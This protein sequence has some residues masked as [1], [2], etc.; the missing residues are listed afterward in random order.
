MEVMLTIGEMLTSPLFDR[1]PRLRIVLA[2]ADIGWL[3]WL[4]A[5]VDRGH[6]RYALQNDIHT[7]LKPSEYFHRN[8]SAVV[9]RGSRRRV[10]SRIHGRG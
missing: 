6:E 9:H 2:E 8:V 10:H 7:K 4:L 5:R 3:P 1:H